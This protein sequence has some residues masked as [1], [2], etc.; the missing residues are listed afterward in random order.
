MSPLEVH[1]RPLSYAYLHGSGRQVSFSFHSGS[2]DTECI[3]CAI[4]IKWVIGHH[5]TNF[6]FGKGGMFTPGQTW[7]KESQ[8]T[9]QLQKQFT[10]RKEAGK[11]QPIGPNGCTHLRL[12]A[13]RSEELSSCSFH[14]SSQQPESTAYGSEQPDTVHFLTRLQEVLTDWVS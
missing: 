13:S 12:K 8:R 11:S 10:L 4:N 2:G 6:A 7:G 3:H 1:L 9:F 5:E 14:D